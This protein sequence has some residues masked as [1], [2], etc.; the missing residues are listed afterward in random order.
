MG[1]MRPQGRTLIVHC[2]RIIR[3]AENAKHC[4][5]FMQHPKYIPQEYQHAEGKED[6]YTSVR[7]LLDADV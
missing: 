3:Y 2:A 1:I 5:L 4:A 7:E 6:K